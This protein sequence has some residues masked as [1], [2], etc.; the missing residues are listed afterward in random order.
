MIEQGFNY[1]DSTIK[2]M[3]N[4]FGIIVENLDPKEEKKKSSAAAKNYMDEKSLKK[5]KQEDSYASAIKSSKDSSVE[6]R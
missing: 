1:A 3:T 2:R 5:R 6:H 4:F